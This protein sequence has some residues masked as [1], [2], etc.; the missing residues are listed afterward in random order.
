MYFEGIMDREGAKLLDRALGSV[1]VGT[2]V[3]ICVRE[4]G[5]HMQSYNASRTVLV[6]FF[7]KENMFRTYEYGG[8]YIFGTRNVYFHKK[9]MRSVRVSASGIRLSLQWDLSGAVLREDLY[10]SR[11]SPMEVRF[12][13]VETFEMCRRMLGAA[14][15]RFRR[16]KEVCFRLEKG[17]LVITNADPKPSKREKGRERERE[18]KT[19]GEVSIGGQR[20][21]SPGSISITI[22]VSATSSAEFTL[23]GALLK[24]VMMDEMLYDR[25]TL[26]VGAND[27]PLSITF[28]SMGFTSSALL[29][30]VVL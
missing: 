5:V 18:K 29:A 24:K 7:V 25:M 8:H 27:D 20:E 14:L 26:S 19:G 1:Y 6:D 16:E 22:P 3:C 4:G 23:P 11:A 28:D 17:A 30:T 21:K 12:E 15:D 2:D 10:I 9:D 13:V